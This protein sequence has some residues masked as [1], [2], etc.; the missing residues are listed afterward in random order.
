MVGQLL[1]DD[2][3]TK[4]MERLVEEELTL[5]VRIP[6]AMQKRLDLLNS[7]PFKAI[8]TTNFD[9]LIKGPTPWSKATPRDSTEGHEIKRRKTGMY[10]THKFTQTLPQACHK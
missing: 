9:L 5:P 1:E 2:I 7:I 8:L 4:P 10:V 6:D 3:G